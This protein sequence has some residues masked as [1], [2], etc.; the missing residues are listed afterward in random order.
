VA[1]GSYYT[2]YE[3]NYDTYQY[4]TPQQD[5]S[6]EGEDDDVDDVRGLTF[7]AQLHI[8]ISEKGLSA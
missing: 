3:T 8:Y 5:D 1:C 7:S 4:G 2:E 6:S